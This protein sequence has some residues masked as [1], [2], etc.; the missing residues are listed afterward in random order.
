MP[1]ETDKADTQTEPAPNIGSI[2]ED[3]ELRLEAGIVRSRLD[4]PP[5]PPAMDPL[6]QIGEN[7][8]IPGTCI[9]IMILLK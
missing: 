4:D 6:I 2:E 9:V 8:P 1:V 5:P 7:D 3:E